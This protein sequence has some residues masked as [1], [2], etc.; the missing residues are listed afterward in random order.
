MGLGVF[1]LE[2]GTGVGV[3]EG[4]TGI[5]VFEG[6]TALGLG[7]AVLDG[8]TGVNVFEGAA[9]SDLE[10]EVEAVGWAWYGGAGDVIEG[11]E[12][13][14]FSFGGGVDFLDEG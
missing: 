12:V 9:S 11:A 4:G 6:G 7:V 3:F 2:G 5:G 8:G 1:A 14:G 13:V 10:C